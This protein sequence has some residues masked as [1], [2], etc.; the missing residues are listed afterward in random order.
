MTQ[1][2][3]PRVILHVSPDGGWTFFVSAGR[4]VSPQVCVVDKEAVEEL[5]KVVEEAR[6]KP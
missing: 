2:I 6:V 3:S 5:V 1:H 4:R